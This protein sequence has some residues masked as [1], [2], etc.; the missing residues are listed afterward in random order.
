[1]KKSVLLFLGTVALLGES[2]VSSGTAFD[3]FDCVGTVGLNQL[4]NVLDLPGCDSRSKLESL[5]KSPGR[6]AS[7]PSGSGNWKH[8]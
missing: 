6:D 7:P 4:S 3:V 1:M 5:R 8:G 2:P